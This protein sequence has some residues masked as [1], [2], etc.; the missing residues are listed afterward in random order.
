M[1]SPEIKFHHFIFCICGSLT[2]F[3]Y[4]G[5]H[6]K[7]P[8]PLEGQLEAEWHKTRMGCVCRCDRPCE[9]TDPSR[10]GRP[11]M[12][13][14]PGSPPHCPHHNFLVC[15]FSARQQ[16]WRGLKY[17]AVEI[18]QDANSMCKRTQYT[19]TMVFTLEY[20]IS[21]TY[22]HYINN[23]NV[24]SANFT[25]ICMLYSTGLQKCWITS[26]PKIFIR[27]PGIQKYFKTQEMKC[28]KNFR[29]LKQIFSVI[30]IP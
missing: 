4:R 8:L 3:A 6:S 1:C 15:S 21:I 2:G 16:I 13:C 7:T 9:C 18:N 20:Y 23:N 28:K 29:Q 14:S 25:C 11:H 26:K 5:K 30:I 24:A 12:V 17:K 19:A 22:T 27:K 10:Q